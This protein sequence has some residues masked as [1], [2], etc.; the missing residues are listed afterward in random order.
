MVKIR[1]CSE[2]RRP[3]RVAD[4][5]SAEFSGSMYDLEF[6]MVC[7]LWWCLSERYEPSPTGTD[8]WPPSMATRL[9]FT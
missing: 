9:M 7:T 5:W 8:L 6:R 4:P 1:R 2:S 3:I